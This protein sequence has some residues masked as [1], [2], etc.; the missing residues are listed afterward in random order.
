M[1]GW[2][3]PSRRP[4]R[5]EPVVIRSHPEEQTRGAARRERD[6]HARGPRACVAVGRAGVGAGGLLPHAIRAARGARGAV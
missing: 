6:G 3:A 5:L 2:C 4:V 1:L